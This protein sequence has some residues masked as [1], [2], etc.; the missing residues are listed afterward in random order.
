MKFIVLLTALLLEQ[1][2]PLRQ[3]NRMQAAFERYAQYLQH[4]LDA[5]EYRQGQ[6]AWCLAV[7]PLTLAV[8][9]LELML[10]TISPVLAWLWGAALLY[11]TVGFRR[12]GNFFNK[13]NNLLNSGDVAAARDQLHRWRN[14]DCSELDADAVARVAI[15][16]G[17]VSSHRHVFAPVAW[18]CGA[19]PGGC[20]AVSVGGV[21]ACAV[22][23]ARHAG[24]WRLRCLCAFRGTRVRR[25]RLGAGARDGGEFCGGRQF[26]GCDGMLAHAGCGMDRPRAGYSPRQRRRR[27]WG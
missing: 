22:A 24:S 7:A 16:L 10:G 2:R 13:I 6:V 23:G 27:R 18:F 5:G 8:F 9:A 1:V 20:A 14:E 3:G 12:F 15:E 17:L 25:T 19:G 21:V 4:Q 11:V 26:S